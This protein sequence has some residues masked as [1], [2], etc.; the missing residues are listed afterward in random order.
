MSDSNRITM[1]LCIEVVLMRRSG[2]AYYHVLSK[3]RSLYDCEIG[4]CYD[5][6]QYLKNVLKDVYGNDY[7]SIVKEIK[8]ELGD[9]IN[10][11]GIAAF[12]EILEYKF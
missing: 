4:D 12:L 11:K 3:L 10:N 5:K 7:E 1:A 6:P 8:L 2:E 9:S